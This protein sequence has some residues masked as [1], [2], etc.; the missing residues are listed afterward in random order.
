MD[1]PLRYGATGSRFAQI[2]K[3]ELSELYRD[4]F[5]GLNF[6][7]GPSIQGLIFQLLS[8]WCRQIS[9]LR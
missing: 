4:Y 6:D 8:G 5:V 3:T 2:S 9:K 7:G 1:P